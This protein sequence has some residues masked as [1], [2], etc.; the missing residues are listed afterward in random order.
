MGKKKKQKKDDSPALMILREVDETLEHQHED[1][2]QEIEELQYRL[3]IEDQKAKKKIRKE[4]RKNPQ[5][6][7][8]SHERINVRRKIIGEMESTNL[9]ERIQIFFNKIGPMVVLV[10]RLVA[11]LIN[12][13]LSITEVK[14]W[15]KP[16]TLSKINKVYN[17]ATSL[18][19]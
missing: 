15:L 6:F 13:L 7:S 2:M 4:L 10:G 14:V 1:I 5:R 3:Y 16:E 17:V 19:M 11:T 18:S 8:S 9:L 12:M